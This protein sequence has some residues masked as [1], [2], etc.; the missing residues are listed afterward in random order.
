MSFNQSAPTVPTVINA[1]NVFVY[2]NTSSGNALSVQQLGAGN[3]F[4]FS[5]AA[6]LSNV[7]VMNNLGQVGIG[8][9]S[10][11]WPLDVLSS[12]SR[13][14]NFVSSANGSG[15]IRF[16]CTDGTTPGTGFIGINAFNNSVFGL[17]SSTG[18]PTVFYQNGTEYMRIHTNGNVGIGTATVSAGL[19]YWGGASS[20]TT[21]GAPGSGGVIIGSDATNGSPGDY[22]PVLH[23]RQSWYTQGQGSVTTG[24]IAGYKTAGSG[25]FGG[26]LAFLY[27]GNGATS[28]SQGMTLTDAGRVGI[29]TT[30][31]GNL[32]T[33][34]NG[35]TDGAVC[36]LVGGNGATTSAG[37]SID[38]SISNLPTYSGASI[39]SL[40]NYTDGSGQS[41]HL[42]FYTANWNGSTG[43]LQERMRITSAGY[44]GIGATN[45]PDTLFVTSNPTA[46][47]VFTVNN[48]ANSGGSNSTAFIHSD[49][50]F[51]VGTTA[52]TGAVLSVTSYPNGVA[53][54]DGYNLKVGTS[55]S[56]EASYAVQ[57][58]VKSK[59]NVGIGT[60]NP[61]STLHT[62]GSYMLGT[63][64]KVANYFTLN[65]TGINSSGTFD[66]RGTSHTISYSS[67]APNN[68]DN[69]T[70]LFIIYASS[71]NTAG[72]Q[73]CAMYNLVKGYGAGVTLTQISKTGYN[74]TTT[75]TVSGSDI[76]VTTDADVAV[77][78]Q[79]FV[80]C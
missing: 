47:K 37:P 57:F 25:S 66:S 4:R 11:G 52:Y 32:L 56:A 63:T 51:S 29:G 36:R 62:H 50:S 54:N 78:W 44:V 77:A 5:N 31:P 21:N 9:P 48:Y 46:N 17:G 2:G 64:W 60:A 70:G 76:S 12:G 16:Q 28:L 58:C 27:C 40:N 22:S 10:P 73:T 6:G 35:T 39:K 55:D 8:T 43:S 65:G 33:V 26:G 30:S 42:A 1:S 38:F 7:M 80:A 23:F 15:N 20:T 41:A 61:T 75:I 13:V 79:F 67:F 18:I 71:G 14:A 45:P 53:N 3:V 34:N 68:A 24:G 72:R 19:Q 69:F 74:A 49:Q 59:G